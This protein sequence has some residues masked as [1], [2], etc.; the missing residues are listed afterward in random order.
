MI[1]TALILSGFLE[2]CPRAAAP[3]WSL[4]CCCPWCWKPAACCHQLVRL[5][6]HNAVLCLLSAVLLGDAMRCILDP[7]GGHSLN[8]FFRWCSFFFFL[9][10]FVWCDSQWVLYL[11]STARINTNNT[12][13]CCCTVSSSLLL[14]AFTPT[15]NKALKHELKVLFCLNTVV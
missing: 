2:H 3:Q 14:L 8:I 12:A 10:Q 15:N 6:M 13:S 7:Q 5:R 4:D 11:L 1:R 9:S